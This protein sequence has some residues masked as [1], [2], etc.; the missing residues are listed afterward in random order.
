M[1]AIIS[2]LT[3]AGVAKAA[4]VAI[5]GSSLLAVV[6]SDVLTTPVAAAEFNGF[7]LYCGTNFTLSLAGLIVAPEYTAA[8]AKDEL[9]LLPCKEDED[10]DGSPVTTFFDRLSTDCVP[11][12][13]FNLAINEDMI[14]RNVC[15][16][17]N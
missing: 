5:V 4:F 16:L 3:G 12:V 1:V 15:V 8:A 6:A 13:A 11:C 14:H 7:F 10:M 9:G 17:T 2:L